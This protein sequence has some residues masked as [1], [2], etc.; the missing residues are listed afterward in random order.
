MIQEKQI[1]KSRFNVKRKKPALS[2][3]EFS[4]RDG[5]FPPLDHFFF[6]TGF[7]VV[8]FAVFFVVPHFFAHAITLLPP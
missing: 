7:F 5:A 4:K 6:G 1:T 3:V 8:F 2:V